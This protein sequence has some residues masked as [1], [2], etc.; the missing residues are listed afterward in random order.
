MEISNYTVGNGNPVARAL[1]SGWQFSGIITFSS[2]A[3][4][5]ITGSGCNTPAI[6]S[7]YI[8]SYNPSFNG[9]VRINGD[10]GTGNALAPGAVAYY[11]KQAFVDPAAYTFG[12]LPRSAP[13]GLFVPGLLDESVSL[14]REIGFNERWKLAIT[15]DVF[16]LTNS[17]HF[18]APGTNI[19]SANFGRVTTTTN[20]PRKFQ[21]NA[22]ITF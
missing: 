2:G 3:P 10:Y 5:A 14:R 1:V 15:A 6:T 11:D 9:P 7:T 13:Y 19:D 18:A 20:L 22:R 8:A 17:V 12:N 4:I 16:N 21:L